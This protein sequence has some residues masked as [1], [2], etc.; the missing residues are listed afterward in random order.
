MQEFGPQILD[1]LS[2]LGDR[3][4]RL[5][6]KID[7]VYEKSAS[8]EARIGR[9]ELGSV[10]NPDHESRLRKLERFVWLIAGA[11]ALGGGVIGNLISSIGGP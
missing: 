4:T 11:A 7:H 5:E 8:L 2:G 9:L 10:P 3:L 6:V 1:R